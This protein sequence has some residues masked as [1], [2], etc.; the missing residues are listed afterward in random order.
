[1]CWITVLPLCDVTKG[2][3]GQGSECQERTQP[4][5]FALCVVSDKHAEGP[6]NLITLA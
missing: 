2:A 3:N 4:L 5:D 1:M 6:T